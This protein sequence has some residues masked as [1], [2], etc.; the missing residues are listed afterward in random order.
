MPVIEA[1]TGN[2]DF[3][4]VHDV[5]TKFGG[6]IQEIDVEAVIMLNTVPGRA[7]GFTLRNDDNRVAHQGMLDL[8]R[9]AFDHNFAITIDSRIEDAD[10]NKGKRNGRIIRA[11]LRKQ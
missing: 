5:G 4:R 10:F 8:L 11:A 7:F 9:D 1:F 6:G 3:L 2:I